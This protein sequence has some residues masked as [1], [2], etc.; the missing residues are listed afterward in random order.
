MGFYGV[1]GDQNN[2]LKYTL[3]KCTKF[4]PYL[5]LTTLSLS[6]GVD[7]WSAFAALFGCFFPY[8][9]VTDVDTRFFCFHCMDDTDLKMQKNTLILF[10]RCKGVNVCFRNPPKRNDTDQLESNRLSNVKT[11]IGVFRVKVLG[12]KHFLEF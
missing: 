5:Y 7:F 12:V 2:F 6:P 4:A 10:R 11:K 1:E 9:L 3:L 8:S